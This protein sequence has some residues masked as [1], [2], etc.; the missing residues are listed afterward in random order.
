MPQI[1]YVLG[2]KDAI[3]NLGGR[4]L[5]SCLAVVGAGSGRGGGVQCCRRRTTG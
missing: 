1:I 5:W 2:S 3:D 4:G